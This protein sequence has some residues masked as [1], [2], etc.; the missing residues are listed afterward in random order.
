MAVNPNL[1]KEDGPTPYET[2]TERIQLVTV[3]EGLEFPWDLAFVDDQTVYVTEKPGR[4]SRVD[5]RS[6]ELSPIRGVPEVAFI[7]QGGLLGLR[8]DPAFAE[9]GLLYFSHSIQVGPELYTTRV[10]RAQLVGDELRDVTPILT[11]EPALP[12][13]H[14]FGGALEF[15]DKGFLL[16][17]VGDRKERADAQDLGSFLGKIHRIETDGSTP[18]DNPFRHK[19]GARPEIMSWGH[20]NPQG[21]AVHP[22]TG[23]IWAAEHGPKG[24][25][26][27]QSDRGGT[28][29]RLADHLARRGILR[30]TCRRRQPPGGPGA[31]R[32]L[33][34][35]LDRH[36]RPRH[37]YGRHAPQ[38]EGEPLRGRID[39]NP[40]QPSL[41]ARTRVRGRRAALQG[42]M[43][44][45]PRHPAIARFSRLLHADRERLAYSHR[46]GPFH[47]VGLP[48]EGTLR[49]HQSDRPR[50]R[51]AGS[52]LSGRVWLCAR[53]TG[54][55][56]SERRTRRGDRP[57]RVASAGLAP[58]ASGAR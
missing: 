15:D 13:I 26:E 6:G 9:N 52:L 14:H 22:E 24:G 45:G 36:L 55:G 53:P 47:A 32:A 42:S 25:D 8:L 35:A 20:R 16:L 44:P 10:S 54:A 56:L 58:A 40:A 49:P 3:V 41:G 37:L 12:G 57:G 43:A 34:R 30:R 31:T 17:S 48:G 4:L 46:A 23:G 5:L 39:R 33:L 21:I 38:L 19:S 2:Q 50:L 18:E 27:N 28:E 7:G 11:A 29:L 1:V 51:W